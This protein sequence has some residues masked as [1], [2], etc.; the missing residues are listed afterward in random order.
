MRKI[1]FS[2]PGTLKSE[3]QEWWEEWS[4]KAERATREYIKKWEAWYLERQKHRAA[5]SKKPPALNDGIWTEFK[6]KLLTSVFGAK[7]GYCEAAKP[8]QWP[9]QIEHYRPKGGVETGSCQNAASVPV[10]TRGPGGVDIDHPGYFWLAYNWR[11][12]IPCCPR[13]NSGNGK[14]TQF[15]VGRRHVFLMPLAAASADQRQRGIPS[16]SWPDMFYPAPQDL[17]CLEEPL[18]IHPCIEQPFGLIT[19]GIRGIGSGAPPKGECTMKTLD[20]HNEGLRQERQDAQEK[21]FTNYYQ[22][23]LSYKIQGE[24]LERSRELARQKLN[25]SF[26]TMEYSAAVR[27]GLPLYWRL[28]A[29]G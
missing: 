19:F 14:N 17:D 12:F 21:G 2:P 10:R 1:D 27:D 5:P 23:I 9:I 11:N 13:C 16:P 7:C 29:P 28:M 22:L 24:T 25:E 4:E 20:L 15:P 8:A 6:N 3:H 18:L 26:P